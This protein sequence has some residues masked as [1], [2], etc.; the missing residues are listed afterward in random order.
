[1]KIRNFLCMLALVVP[2]LFYAE[3][4]HA[5]WNTNTYV[6]LMISSLSDDDQQSIATTDGK[7]W[8]AF[9]SQNGSD[10]NMR[11]QLIDANGNKMLGTDGML[12]SSQPTGSATFVF[13]VC[14][15]ASNNLIIACQ[16][17]RSG[18][19]QAVLYKIS[20]SGTHLWSSSGV[21]LGSG[22][23]PYP[24]VLST[25]EVVV[26]WNE[27]NSNTLNIQKI[28]T[29]GTLAWSTPV[30]VMVGTS[31]TTRGQIFPCTGGKFSM[32]FQKRSYGISTTLYAQMFDNNG[33][34][35]Y[36]AVQICNETTSGARYYSI[37]G[38]GDVTYFGYYSSSSNR[39]NSYIQRI[40]ADGSLPWGI[41]GSHFNTSTSSG[42]NYQV[43][44]NIA[45]TNGSSYIWAVA[46]FCD[47][48]QTIY[49]VYVQKFIKTTGARQFTDQGKVVYAVSANC[50]RQEGDIALVSDTPMFMSYDVSEKIYATRLDASGNFVWNPFRVE[51]SSTTATASVPKMRYGFTP[52]GPNRCAGVWTENRGSGYRGYAQG[53][54]IGGLIGLHVATQ[55]NVPPVISTSGGTL[56]MVDTIIPAT[57]SQ[58]VTWSIVPGTGQASINT[59]GLVTAISNG[60]VWAKA[61]AVQDV[62]LK[63]SLMITISNQSSPLVTTTAATNI[64]LYTATVNGTVNANNFTCTVTFDWGLTTSYGNT[65]TAT[66]PTVTGNT[67]VPV[68][69]NLSGLT[70][71]T[72]Y[73]FRCKATN[74]YGTT[75]GQD[76]TFTT[77]CIPVGAAGPITGPASVCANST[78]K[79]YSVDSVSNATSYLWTLPSGAYITNGQN[80]RTITVTF[81]AVSGNISVSG[82]NGCNS[83]TSSSLAVTVIPSPVPTITGPNSACVSTNAVT[84]STEAGM[85]SY[86][87]TISSGGT[88]ISGTG[89]NQISVQWTAAGSQSLTVTYASPEG[90][91]PFAP[92]FLG[93]TVNAVPDPAGA[94]TG[95]S[96]VC[97]G[98][99]GVVYSIDSVANAISYVW[100]VPTGGTI[101]TGQGTSSITVNYANTATSG[102]VTVYASNSCGDGQSSSMPVSVNP[103]P[104]APVITLNYMTILSSNT[105]TGN[106]WYKDG[107]AIT[108]ATGQTWN[109]QLTGNGWYWDVVSLEGCSSDT[110]NNIYVIVE[111]IGNYPENTFSIYPNPSNGRF[112][113]LGNGS[114]SG[115]FDMYVINS[116]G[117]KVY[118]AKDININ[119]RTPATIDLSSLTTGLYSVILQN[120]NI[121][122][123]KKVLIEK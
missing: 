6:N 30:Q 45:Q 77:A 71:N 105:A 110:S 39:F 88:I 38:E 112:F 103:I 74:S 114:I 82:S 78:G 22:L 80:T 91:T 49:G 11:A 90:C 95:L 34:S 18:G 67:V 62:T 10:Y 4:V 117:A 76:L 69:A 109:C 79:V 104:P 33:T 50:D 83:G 36:T 119:R 26:A 100:N 37:T 3:F 122:I 87:W 102:N 9:Y 51:I 41:N 97:A 113:I 99:Q 8:I 68:L 19:D 115:N 121:W 13:N 16:D 65:A 46:T 32:V 86:A 20:Q 55:N 42:D 24:A 2:G 56:Q 120:N 14:I 25:G 1:M 106:Q 44:T 101:A 111:G 116:I 123:I 89:T 61:V 85:N 48:N 15:D 64:G 108:G 43:E 40:N 5:Q 72:V 63:D 81:G 59:T 35:Q 84:Y 12:V 73:H 60:T 94:V 52:D 23:A 66:P 21:I 107:S 92:A 98:Q 27:S 31:T 118:S 29:S 70:T 28:T 58:S 17:E 7:T 54:T 93:V 53:I 96:T 47:P 57:A 75:Y